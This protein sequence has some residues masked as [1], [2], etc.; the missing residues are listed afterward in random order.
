[1]RITSRKSDL[2]CKRK[3]RSPTISVKR[4]IAAYKGTHKIPTQ[5]DDAKEPICTIETQA[6]GYDVVSLEAVC[7]VFVDHCKHSDSWD[8]Q[9]C[10]KVLLG[11]EL[12]PCFLFHP[13]ILIGSELSPC[14]L[15]HPAILISLGRISF[16]SVFTWQGRSKT[17]RIKTRHQHP[18]RM[19]EPGGLP[20]VLA[21]VVDTC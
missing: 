18:V 9:A 7:L 17:P 12:S 10:N 15:F 2:P 14:F 20:H 4:M 13:A 19:L 16:Q 3:H 11:S 6:E 1:V 21:V 8:P 5:Q